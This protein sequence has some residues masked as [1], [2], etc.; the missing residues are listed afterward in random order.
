MPVLRRPRRFTGSAF[1][2]AFTKVLYRGSERARALVG[3]PATLLS[4]LRRPF[5]ISPIRN[6][7]LQSIILTTLPFFTHNVVSCVTAHSRT[8]WEDSGNQN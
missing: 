1:A 4:A 7:Q 2:P 8:T 5:A 6:E 3:W